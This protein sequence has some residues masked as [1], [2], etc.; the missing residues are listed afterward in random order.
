MYDL[1]K[2]QFLVTGGSRGIGAG[3]V[4]YLAK[5]GSQVAFTYASDKESAEKV[6]KNL[7]GNGH[8]IYQ[9][10]ISD[11]ANIKTTLKQI[12]L[13]FPD[14]DGLVNNAG[15]A[16]DKILLRM[17]DSDFDEVIQTNLKGSF[18]CTKIILKR[19]LKN[20]KGVLIHITSIVGQRGQAGQANY[21]ASK[22]GL[23]AFSKSISLEMASQG[24]RSNCI[25]PGFIFTD[26]TNQLSQKQIETITTNIPLSR[27]G[28]VQDIAYSCGFLLSNHS[29][30]IT[31][32]TLS[33]NGGLYM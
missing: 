30:Y 7:S 16:R 20:K 22:A 19:M 18:L 24:I 9:L 31:G 28:T 5:C 10:D 27:I 3:I 29:D 14:I 2:K 13:D 6:L 4:E 26:M 23:E 32:Q 15:I 11:A 25:A 33:V 21:A 8:K 17:K 12:L 1:K